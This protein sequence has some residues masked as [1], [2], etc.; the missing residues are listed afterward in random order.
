MTGWCWRRLADARS[1]GMPVVMVNGSAMPAM[2]LAMVYAPMVIVECVRRICAEN[3][4]LDCS[5]HCPVTLSPNH[6]A[7][8]QSKFLHFL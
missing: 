1:P 4:I 7:R 2:D 3:P 8:N 6:S 5:I